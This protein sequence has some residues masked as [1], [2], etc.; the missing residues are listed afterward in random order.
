LKTKH[1]KQRNSSIQLV[2]R[3]YGADQNIKILKYAQSI[4]TSNNNTVVLKLY[5]SELFRYKI[6]AVYILSAV[7]V[8]SSCDQHRYRADEARDLC[9]VG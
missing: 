1:Y 7:R 2:H 6:V 3:P 8:T 9:R 5:G 4:S